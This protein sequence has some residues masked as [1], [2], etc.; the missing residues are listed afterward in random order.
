MSGRLAVVVLAGINECTGRAFDLSRARRRRD[1]S[2]RGPG[3]H[4]PTPLFLLIPF[5]S[6]LERESRASMGKAA[7]KDGGD[8]EDMRGAKR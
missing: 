7:K 8:P 1:A 2:H 5:N 6:L 3:G 4:F